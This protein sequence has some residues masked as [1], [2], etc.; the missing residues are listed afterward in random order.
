MVTFLPELEKQPRPS[1]FR[2]CLP[3][4]LA[5]SLESGWF[6]GVSE[7]GLISSVFKAD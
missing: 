1:L 5:P 6:G 3:C 7:S 4:F 2:L